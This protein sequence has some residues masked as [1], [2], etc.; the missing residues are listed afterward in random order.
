[1]QRSTAR[2]TGNLIRQNFHLVKE[3]YPEITQRNLATLR[4]L[5]QTLRLSVS[6][7]DLLNI[8]GKW[9]VTHA[10]LLRIASRRRCLGIRTMLQREFCDPAAARWVFK[11]TLYKHPGTQGFVG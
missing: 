1:M 2:S 4:E 9:Y 6:V 5:T 3:L 10:G 11:A 7:G 8:D